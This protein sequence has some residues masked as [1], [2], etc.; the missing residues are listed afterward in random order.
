[1]CNLHPNLESTHKAIR[2]KLWEV[3]KKTEKWEG[4]QQCGKYIFGV[5]VGSI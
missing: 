3:H 1:M 2:Q 4:A 5:E